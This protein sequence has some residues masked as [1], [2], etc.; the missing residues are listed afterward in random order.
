[1][2]ASRTSSRS[3]ARSWE[4]T[5]GSPGAFG[6][7]IVGLNIR[8]RAVEALATPRTLQG[9]STLSPGVNENTPNARQLSINGGL[10]Y[11]NNMMID[12]VDI[13]TAKESMRLGAAKLS[14]ATKF[15]ARAHA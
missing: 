11:D 12:G 3:C 14:V 15:V 13:E 1:M 5:P 6:R 7:S 9:I 4:T 8:Q 10:A 2:R